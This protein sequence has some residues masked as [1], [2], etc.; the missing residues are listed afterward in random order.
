MIVSVVDIG[1]IVVFLLIS[2][3]VYIIQSA[4]H[5]ITMVPKMSTSVCRGTT[6]YS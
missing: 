3:Y 6:L 5:M 4:E 1:V 2:V